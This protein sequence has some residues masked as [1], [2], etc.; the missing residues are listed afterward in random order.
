M[1]GGL[2]FGFV[3]F[4]DVLLVLVGLE[5]CLL[6]FVLF[7]FLKSNTPL[8]LAWDLKFRFRVLKLCC[9]INCHAEIM[10][11]ILNIFSMRPH[12]LKEEGVGSKSRLKCTFLLSKRT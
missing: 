10:L 6:V 8:L 3:F 4:C 7:L 9:I 12:Y 2:S 5:L 11:H 1:T